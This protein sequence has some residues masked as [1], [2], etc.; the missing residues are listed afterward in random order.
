MRA[1]SSPGTIRLGDVVDAARLQAL[2]DVLGI[3][4]AGHEDDGD[5][6]QRA[7]LLQ[8]AA[9]LKA[10]GA[11]HHRIHEDHVGRYFLDDRKGMITF[12]GHQDGH[13]GL[14]DGIGQHA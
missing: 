9:G 5:M 2:N 6:R 3:A 11:G 14:F 8:T 1:R 10:V 4:Q 7:V 13:A 12:A